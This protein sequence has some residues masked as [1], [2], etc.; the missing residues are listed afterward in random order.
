MYSPGVSPVTSEVD[1]FR[2]ACALGMEAHYPEVFSEYKRLDADCV[3]FSSTREGKP[4]GPAAF[5]A[6][7]QGHAATN[8]YWVGFSVGAQ[9]SAIASSGVVAPGGRWL[10]RCPADGHASVVT[11]DLDEESEGVVGALRQARP[12]RGI[13]RSGEVYDPHWVRD[14]P[15]SA[16]RA[17]F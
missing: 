6:E 5:A 7:V 16:N 13:A 1:G 8:R 15:R 17:G 12:W 9:Q 3:L 10:A 14:D 4:G 11:V 2:F